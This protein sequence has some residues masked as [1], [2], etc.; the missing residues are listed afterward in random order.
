MNPRYV[1]R[2]E[3]LAIFAAATAAYFLLN[4]PAWLYLLLFFA[5]DLSMV[6]YVANPASGAGHT[7]RYTLTYS[8]S[9]CWASESGKPSRWLRS[10]QRSG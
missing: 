10:L 3:G 5:P 8:R 6:G 2:I 4:G 9:R 1:L 7:T